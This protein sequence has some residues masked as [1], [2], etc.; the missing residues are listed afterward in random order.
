VKSNTHDEVSTSNVIAKARV[1]GSIEKMENVRENCFCKL[2]SGHVKT[3]V[4]SNVGTLPRPTTARAA[5]E[6]F[7]IPDL[8]SRPFAKTLVSR[9]YHFLFV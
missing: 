7:K 3:K 2:L 4:C 6:T 9:F 5:L 8:P 1:L